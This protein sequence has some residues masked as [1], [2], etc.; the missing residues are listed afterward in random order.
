MVKAAATV[1]VA[2]AAKIDQATLE[3]PEQKHTSTT[4]DPSLAVK[5]DCLGLPDASKEII[6]LTSFLRDNADIFA[7]SPSGMLGVRR[8]LADHALEVNNTTRP[9]KQK[10]Q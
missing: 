3:V 9:I 4:L 1:K 8:E 6:A 2:H 10:L 5:K 7:W